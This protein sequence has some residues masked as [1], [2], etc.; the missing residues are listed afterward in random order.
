MSNREILE[1]CVQVKGQKAVSLEVLARL[2]GFEPLTEED[3]FNI[4]EGRKHGTSKLFTDP[5]SQGVGRFELQ[6]EDDGCD[7]CTI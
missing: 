7:G 4:V 5:T 2:M 3:K 6:S 1:A